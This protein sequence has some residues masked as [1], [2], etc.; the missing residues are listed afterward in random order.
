MNFSFRLN[1]WQKLIASPLSYYQS[2]HTGGNVFP[3][4]FTSSIYFLR[5]RRKQIKLIVAKFINLPFSRIINNV[6][7]NSFVRLFVAYDVFGIIA[8][9]YFT[10]N[11]SHPIVYTPRMYSFVVIGL[12]QSTTSPMVAPY[13]E[14]CN[15]SGSL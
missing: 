2:T 14:L 9:L 12:N 7:R 6:L 15:P 1:G 8:L 4:V 10:L 11:D 13:L 3:L 5:S